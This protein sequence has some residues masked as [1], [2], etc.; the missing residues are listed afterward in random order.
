MSPDVVDTAIN[1]TICGLAIVFGTLIMLVIIISLFGFIM[2]GAQG[3]GKKAKAPKSSAKA[4]PA[5]VVSAPAVTS[6]PA[7]SDDDEVI[8]VIS[9]A[10]AAMY[11]GSGKTFAVRNI[12]PVGTGARSAWA[13]AGIARNTRAF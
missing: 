5:S 1:I 11:D 4:A 13:A 12:R 2:K 6:V 8:A 3:I 10:V 9:A 7:A